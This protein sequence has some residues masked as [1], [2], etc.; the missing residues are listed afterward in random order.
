MGGDERL[1][2]LLGRL[3][4]L[5]LAADDDR[6]LSL[7]KDLEALRGDQWMRLDELARRIDS[8]VLLLTG[9]ARGTTWRPSGAVPHPLAAVAASM[10]SDGRVRERAVEHLRHSRGPA[11]A[12][13]VAVRCD[14]WVP[15]VAERAAAALDGY[16]DPPEVAAVVGIMLRLV[17]RRRGSSTATDYLTGL[18]EGEPDGLLALTKAGERA[19]RVWALSAAHARGLLSPDDLLDRALRDADPPIA[20]WCA[21]Q[22]IQG[23]ADGDQ[24]L[25]DAARLLG[26]RRGIVRATAVE[27]LP[28]A[29]LLHLEGD[30]PRLLRLLLDPSGGV[31]TLA[32][33]RWA[34]ALGAPTGEYR[35]ALREAMSRS[36][37]GRSTRLVVALEGLGEC[38]LDDAVPDARRLVADPSPRVRATAV[39]VLGRAV[40]RM[41]VEVEALLPVLDDPANRVAALAVHYLKDRAGEIPTETVERLA[42]SART[43][44]RITALRFRQ[45]L[46]ALERVRRNLLATT[47]PDPEIR[48]LGRADLLAWLQNGAAS[49]YG[50]PSPD[51]RH[52][53]AVSLAGATN[54]GRLS[55]HQAR[56]I[57]FV[58]GLPMTTQQ[59]DTPSDADDPDDSDIPVPGKDQQTPQPPAAP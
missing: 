35:A 46:G 21:R 55:E 26:S 8:D 13:A 45:R 22:L 12:A 16:D 57:A 20:L 9:T 41:S 29:E 33:W 2:E 25:V 14:D 49:T 5:V 32:R 51:Q 15:N 11:V 34:R 50:Q 6:A 42:D 54:H 52:D 48:D 4:V 18:R 47:D 53:I 44:D 30:R 28:D 27:L 43:R 24:A 7:R 39:R 17:H 31:R 56:E 10:S 59:V 23:S 3:A 37:A 19:C 1:T 40:Q 58:S 36:G 38:S